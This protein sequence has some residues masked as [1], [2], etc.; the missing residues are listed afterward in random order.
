MCL[1]KPGVELSFGAVLLVLWFAWVNGWRLTGQILLAAMLHECGHWS[2]LCICGASVRCFRVGVM[3]AVLEVDT[4][5]LSYGQELAA[6]L[7]GPVVNLAAALLGGMQRADPVFIGIHAVL[8]VFNLLPVSLLDGGRAL[9]LLL[10]LLI[11]PDRGERLADGISAAA[12][13]ALVACLLVVMGRTGGS[14]WLLPPAC[15]MLWLGVTEFLG[16]R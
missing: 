2:A 14:L 8:C 16:K 3:G 1:R 15:W 9:R 7:A 12:A 11:G 4:R 6:V 5:C 13:V 10:V